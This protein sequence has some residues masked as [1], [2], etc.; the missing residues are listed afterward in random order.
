MR[1]GRVTVPRG[2]SCHVPPA[3]SDGGRLGP[4][5]STPSDRPST[6]HR[7]TI[8]ACSR[9]ADPRIWRPGSTCRGRCCPV[10]GRLDAHQRAR[11]RRA[12]WSSPRSGRCGR[13]LPSP[14]VVP[15]GEGGL[16][17]LELL[18]SDGGPWLYAYYTSESRQPHRAD[19][20]RRGTR[21][22]SGS[23]SR[24]SSST[25]SQR[26][27]I[28]TAAGS[29]SDPTACCTRPSGD[30]GETSRSQDL[31][32]LNGKILRMTPDRG[33]ARRTT[34]STRLSSG[35][36]AIAT[37]RASPGRTTARCTPPNSARTPGTS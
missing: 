20:P 9:R 36:T 32:S 31:G 10:A 33:G 26:R 12:S 27:A 29:P 13:W 18:E 5:D 19:A 1:P 35:R 21:A 8:G 37:R 30:A 16:L 6:P 3:C 7:P 2:R 11:R 14:G 15:G 25:A 34:R 22:A 24:R 28:T 17:G 4:V 23:G